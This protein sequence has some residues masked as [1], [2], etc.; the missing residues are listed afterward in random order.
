MMKTEQITIDEMVLKLKEKFDE[1]KL[2]ISVSN[3]TETIIVSWYIND[4]DYNTM[5]FNYDSKEDYTVD[6]YFSLIIN[7]FADHNKD[8][9]KNYVVEYKAPTV[10]RFIIDLINKYDTEDF[11]NVINGEIFGDFENQSV[12][13]DNIVEFTWTYGDVLKLTE[14]DAGDM[15]YHT[16]DFE[17]KSI[18]TKVELLEFEME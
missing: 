2:K 17:K 7:T 9:E 8:N 15:Y 10:E 18:E 14:C 11:I 3:T 5:R 13:I 6:D 4:Y 1:A 16:L 12:P